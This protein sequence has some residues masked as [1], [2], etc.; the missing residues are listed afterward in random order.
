MTE[1]GTEVVDSSEGEGT[2]E[3]STALLSGQSLFTGGQLPHPSSEKI[4][5]REVVMCFDELL[6]TSLFCQLFGGCYSQFCEDVTA[7]REVWETET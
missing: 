7:T 3:K 2:E 1:E 4:G 5:D 6:R